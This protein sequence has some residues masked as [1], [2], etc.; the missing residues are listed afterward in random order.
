MS[1]RIGFIGLG[2][3]GKPMA[4][5]LV[6]AGFEVTVYDLNPEPVADLVALGAKSA[7]TP[8]AVAEQSDIIASVVMNNR[9]TLEVFLEGDGTGVLAGAAPGSLIVIHSTVS[10]ELCQQVANAAALKGVGVIDAAVSGAAAKSK[11]GTLTIMVGGEDALVARCQPLFDVVGEHVFHM[12]GLGMG[13][14]AKICNNLVS[15]VSV[16]VIEEG[17]RLAGAAGIPEDKFRE[18]AAVSSAD[19]WALRNI[20]QMRDLGVLTS[21]GPFDM[22]IFGRKDISLAVKYAQAIDC[23]L[24]ITSFVFD[25]AK[26]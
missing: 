10:P 21:K 24:P 9:Q 17:I 14:A 19:S 8:R 5:N 15:L 22:S 11:A 16:H 13:Q 26:L 4:E 3:M 23:D 1:D 25:R 7:Q 2:N 20:D 12:G 6:R 18:L